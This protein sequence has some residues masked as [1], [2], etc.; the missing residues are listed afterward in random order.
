MYWVYMA[1]GGGL[2]YR[3]GFCKKLPEASPLLDPMSDGSKTDLLLAEAE[4]ISDGGSTSGITDLRREKNCC[5]TAD[6]REE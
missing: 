1:S 2:S 5:R 3:G 6:R 4:P